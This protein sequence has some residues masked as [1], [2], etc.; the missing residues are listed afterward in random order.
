MV[1]KNELV[2]FNPYW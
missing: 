2:A 1:Y